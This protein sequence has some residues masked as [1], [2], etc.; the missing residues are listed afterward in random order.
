M[1]EPIQCRA[2]RFAEYVQA[3]LPADVNMF[4][5]ANPEYGT[6]AHF[7]SDWEEIDLELVSPIFG[8]IKF[9]RC[10]PHGVESKFMIGRID[11]GRG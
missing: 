8:T 10:C 11:T 1:H 9:T 3:K 2:N 6:V 4:V 5:T 7:F